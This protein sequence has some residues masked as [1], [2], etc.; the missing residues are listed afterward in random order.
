MLIYYLHLKLI[1]TLKIA[2]FFSYLLYA[3]TYTP[4]KVK[5]ILCNVQLLG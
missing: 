5:P 1:K 4:L 2:L 3:V